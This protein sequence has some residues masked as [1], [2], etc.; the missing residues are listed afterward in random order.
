MGNLCCERY[1]DLYVKRNV[2]WRCGRGFFSLFSF[3]PLVSS[4]SFA[5]QNVGFHVVHARFFGVQMRR[6]GRGTSVMVRVPDGLM[7][8]LS[9]SL[10]T[11]RTLERALGSGRDPFFG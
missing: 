5:I 10:W 1:D 7:N 4:K 11:F 6:K 8:N 2:W 3:L 9:L